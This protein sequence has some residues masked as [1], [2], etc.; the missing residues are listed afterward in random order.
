MLVPVCQLSP[1]WTQKMVTSTASGC[2]SAF[3]RL[4][5]KYHCVHFAKIM[6]VCSGEGQPSF[7]VLAVHYSG[8]KT[9]KKIVLFAQTPTPSPTDLTSDFII[10]VIPLKLD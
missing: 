10:S 3:L 8:H 2:V 4:K 9:E 5:Q 6:L 1:V 7:C